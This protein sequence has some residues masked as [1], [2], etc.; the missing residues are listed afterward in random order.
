MFFFGGKLYIV[1]KLEIRIYVLIKN[2][3]YICDWCIICNISNYNVLWIVYSINFFYMSFDLCFVNGN[4][5]ELEVY[6]NKENFFVLCGFWFYF[7]SSSLLWI[8][9]G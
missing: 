9:M 6:K 1:Y 7:G 8:L 3:V 5:R 2:S 4:Y